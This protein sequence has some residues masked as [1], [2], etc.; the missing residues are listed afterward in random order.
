MSTSL[1]FGGTA[2]EQEKQTW[3]KKQIRELQNFSEDN[4]SYVEDLIVL[5]GMMLFSEKLPIVKEIAKYN[6]ISIS[7]KVDGKTKQR[8]RMVCLKR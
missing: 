1:S 2:E 7:M 6:S 8:I 5:F 3:R 4:E